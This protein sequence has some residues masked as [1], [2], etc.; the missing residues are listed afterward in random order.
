MRNDETSGVYWNGMGSEV[1][2]N[3]ILSDLHGC[4]WKQLNL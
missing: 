4:V 1:Q 2:A 3:N